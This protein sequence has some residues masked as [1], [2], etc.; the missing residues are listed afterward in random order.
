[1]TACLG[2]ILDKDANQQTFFG[3]GECEHTSKQTASDKD[4]HNDDIMCLKVNN[5]GDRNFA[6]SG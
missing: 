1:M 3:G 4:G 5:N 6:V 2:V